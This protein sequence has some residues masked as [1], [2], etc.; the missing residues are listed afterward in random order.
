M[1]KT[2][3]T[4]EGSGEFPFDMLRYNGCFPLNESDSCKLNMHHS[5]LRQVQLVKLH[6]DR[7]PE[8]TPRRWLSFDWRII[9]G[10]V[11]TSRK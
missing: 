10:T 1:Y 9:E 11:T 8:L 7:K 3:F 4:V 5:E 2:I 6:K